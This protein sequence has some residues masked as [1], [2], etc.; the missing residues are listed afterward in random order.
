MS[1]IYISCNIILTSVLIGLLLLLLLLL[2]YMSVGVHILRNNILIISR[3]NP[4]MYRQDG[5]RN[6]CYVCML[7]IMKN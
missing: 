1:C 6:E 7:V 3:H 2:L 4:L 5:W